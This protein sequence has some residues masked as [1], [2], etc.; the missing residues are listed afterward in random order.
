DVVSGPDTVNQ[1]IADGKIAASMIDKF[2]KGQ[3][4]IREYKVTRPAIKVEAVTLTEDELGTIK[5]PVI[6][7]LPI[8]ERQLNFK[9]TELGFTEE[10]AVNEAK[11]CFRCDL[12]KN[13]EG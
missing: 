1:A 12:E 7:V 4:L 13:E 3:P 10:M 11:R 6:P 8:D 2:V 9:E 5:V